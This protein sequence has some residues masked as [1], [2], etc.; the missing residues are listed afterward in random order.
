MQ[1]HE[2]VFIPLHEKEIKNYRL[3][4]FLSVILKLRTKYKRKKH[5]K[6]MLMS[7]FINEN[8]KF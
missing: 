5:I 2:K 8:T 3:I 6:D 1:I 7:G 4:S